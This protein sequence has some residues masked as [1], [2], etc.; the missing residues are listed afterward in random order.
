M[1]HQVLY[2][3]WEDYSTFSV[4]DGI[5]LRDTKNVK[6]YVRWNTLYIETRDGQTYEIEATD[7]PALKTPEVCRVVDSDGTKEEE[8]EFNSEFQSDSDSDFETESESE[9]E[10]EESK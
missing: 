5:D 4:P 10:E 7:N 3:D 2:C 9:S 8:V 1:S 6:W